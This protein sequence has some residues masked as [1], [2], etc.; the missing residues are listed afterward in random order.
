MALQCHLNCASEFC[1][2]Q[3][4]TFFLKTPES[5]PQL[6]IVYD[7][8]DE[9]RR[10]F[11]ENGF[12]R[13]GRVGSSWVIGPLDPASAEARD[14]EYELALAC[15]SSG[16]LPHLNARRARALIRPRGDCQ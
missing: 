7:A 6:L 10:A 11:F 16:G 9:L 2:F 14:L 5:E 1:F 3:P 8:P 13:Y 12:R 4:G 15:G